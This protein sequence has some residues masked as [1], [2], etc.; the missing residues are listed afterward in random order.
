M[1]KR[2][3]ELLTSL[4]SVQIPLQPGESDDFARFCRRRSTR[5][6]L[7]KTALA[8]LFLLPVLFLLH[9]GDSPNLIRPG[10]SLSPVATELRLPEI[11]EAKPLKRLSVRKKTI[12]EELVATA[13][14]SQI[15]KKKEEVVV[16]ERS[17]PE[18]Q[19]EPATHVKE[20][21][22]GL[23]EET[24]HTYKREHRKN[25]V[26][27]FL[28]G[29]K[30]GTS[31][32][33]DNG[34]T[35]GTAEPAPPSDNRS[36]YQYNTPISLGLDYSFHLSSDWRLTLGLQIKGL[37]SE[38][39]GENEDYLQRQ[40][41]FYLG[42]P[43]RLDRVWNL[44]GGRDLYI[45]AGALAERRLRDDD[46]FFSIT[47]GVGF[48]QQISKHIAFYLEPVW[49]YTLEATTTKKR[50]TNSSSPLDYRAYH[51]FHLTLRAGLRYDIIH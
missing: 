36:E 11:P 2:F 30:S 45:G 34:K 29:G 10:L 24:P 19:R 13:A 38:C 43:A 40:Q 48:Q 44:E 26:S 15:P 39:K 22:S 47:G 33:P 1:T 31:F 25:S 18:G 32:R 41:F 42:A 21:S 12:I 37:I 50:K 9:G 49:E 51:P 5:R 8:L 4:N 6:I 17:V 23:W 3:D 27:L 16:I 14:T 46:W 7:S 20:Q 35:A 28:S